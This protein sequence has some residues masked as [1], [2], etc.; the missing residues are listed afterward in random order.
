MKPTPPLPGLV[1]TGGMELSF[2]I[3]PIPSMLYFAVFSTR[4]QMVARAHRLFSKGQVNKYPKDGRTQAFCCQP[5]RLLRKGKKRF[6]AAIILNLAD[7]RAFSPIEIVA[8]EAVHAAHHLRTTHPDLFAAYIQDYPEEAIA[9]PT[10]LITSLI[11]K[12]LQRQKLIQL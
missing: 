4:K 9:Y 8:H 12:E 3:Y 11:T 10:G 6:F 7:L 5:E 2:S 1:L